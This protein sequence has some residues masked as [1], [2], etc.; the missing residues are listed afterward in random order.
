LNNFEL[1]RLL[2]LVL[3]RLLAHAPA[4]PKNAKNYVFKYTKMFI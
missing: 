2:V 4:G 3:V 1:T